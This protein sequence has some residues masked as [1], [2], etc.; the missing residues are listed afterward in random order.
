MATGFFRDVLD[1][2]VIGRIRQT[3]TD[4]LLEMGVAKR[5]ASRW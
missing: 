4:Y 3:Y 5:A 1:K 2:E